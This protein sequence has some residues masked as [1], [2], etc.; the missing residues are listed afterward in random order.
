M[1]EKR[2]C[3][4]CQFMRLADYG[5]MIK[6]GKTNRWKCTACTLKINEPRYAKKSNT[7]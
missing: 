5:K 6:A 1:T 2:Y 4:S 7:N 3:T